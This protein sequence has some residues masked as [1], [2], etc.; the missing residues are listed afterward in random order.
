MNFQLQIYFL[1]TFSAEIR[2]LFDPDKFPNAYE[3]ARKAANKAGIDRKRHLRDKLD[4]TENL[5][6]AVEIQAEEQSDNEHNETG[7]D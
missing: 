5:T 7:N 4:E 6:K 1:T 2:R 3:T